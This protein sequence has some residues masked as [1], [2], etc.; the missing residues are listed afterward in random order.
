MIQI[1]DKEFT[2][3]VGFVK[4]Y[5][6]I[7]LKEKRTLINGRLQNVL[8]QRSFT[9]FGQLIEDLKHDQTGQAVITLINKLTT[10][11]TFFMRENNHFDFFRETVLPYLVSTSKVKD[12]RIW[13]AGCSSGEEAYTLAMI[14]N[15]FLG[16][17]KGLWDSKILATDI[18]KRVLELAV[19]GIYSEEQVA[20]LPE[21]WRK[22]YFKRIDSE[23]SELVDRIKNEVIFRTFNL[24]NSVFPFKKK[25]QVIFCRNVMIY[26]DNPTKKELVRKFYEVTENGGYLFIG[27]SESLG[28]D[29]TRYQY[30]C[31][32][33]YRKHE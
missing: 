9:S 28:R 29:E 5:C 17:E 24:N 3:L 15:D 31:P 16:T 21:G 33:V 2:E 1:T 30:V 4:D 6:G 20:N 18:S 11:H 19:E 32:A 12:L 14:V 22:R 13:S 10:N 8:Q 27:H 26:F 7:N 25:F 23:R